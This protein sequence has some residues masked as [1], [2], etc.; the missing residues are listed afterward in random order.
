[1]AGAYVD[2]VKMLKTAQACGRK[3]SIQLGTLF[4]KE[5]KVAKRLIDADRRWHQLDEGQTAYDSP[6]SHW[7]AA[8]RGQVALLP[9][10]EIALA[11]MLISEGIYL[12]DKLGREVTA[13][14]VLENSRSAAVM[15]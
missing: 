7:V 4:D 10:A 15:I 9:T 8:L 5:T 12:S 6:Q 3:L 14:E 11:T 1:M 2:A 13:D